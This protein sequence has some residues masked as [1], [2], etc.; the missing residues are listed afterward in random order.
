MQL[1]GFKC[2]HQRRSL[3]GKPGTS[4]TLL[5]RVV[6]LLLPRAQVD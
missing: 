6:L 4:F 1:T 2:Q 3:I 5:L